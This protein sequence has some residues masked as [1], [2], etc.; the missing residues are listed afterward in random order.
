MYVA[1][2]H[3]SRVP[4]PRLSQRVAG[5]EFHVRADDRFGDWA[6]SGLGVA[7]LGAGQRKGEG[8][9]ESDPGTTF[10]RAVGRSS[11]SLAEAPA[12]A[13][14]FW[15]SILTPVRDSN[16]EHA[17]EVVVLEPQDPQWSGP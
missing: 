17:R 5:E 3:S 4:P 13:D 7:S 2:S 16:V 8:H 6:L 1:A 12:E 15:R 10:G 9:R 14:H 11:R